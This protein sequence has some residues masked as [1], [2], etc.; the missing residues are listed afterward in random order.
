MKQA[1]EWIQQLELIKH[2]E[3]GYFK[4]VYRSDT[5][6]QV[7]ENST[8]RNL[9]TSIY[10]LLPRNQVSKFHV[11]KS[12]EMW[13]YHD[14]A[15]FC[16]HCIHPSKGYYKVH[17]GKHIQQKQ[18]LQVLISAG[19]IF[20]AELLPDEQFNYGLVGCMVSPGF[21]FND[22]KLVSTPEIKEMLGTAY[23]GSLDV[24]GY[25]EDTSTP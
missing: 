20:A 15:G 7:F 3:G 23:Q 1:Q 12:D 11:L 18:H 21:D 6:V 14:G 8:L 4:E 19:T 10:F 2:P 22:F 16:I 25:D 17:L 9:S 13:Y 5:Q 24:F